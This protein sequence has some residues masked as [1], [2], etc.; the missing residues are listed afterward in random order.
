MTF[1]EIVAQVQSRLNLTSTE[2]TTRIGVTV[3]DRYKRITSAIG[4]NLSRRTTVQANVTI[5]VST[6]TFLLCEKIIN[7]VDRSA[8]PYRVLTECTV[9]QLRQEQPASNATARKYA[10]I[11][12]D[13]HAVTILL[14]CV[15]QTAFTLYADCYGRAST[16][17]GSQEPAFEEDFHDVLLHGAL[18]DEYR[19]MEKPA[20]A[21]ESEALYQERLSDLRMFRAKS[22]YLDV[23]QGGNTRRSLGVTGGS[24][25][26][27]S[28]T[29]GASSYTQTGLITFDR[30]SA[31]A[32]SRYP[33]AV[34]AGSEKVAN[35]DADKLDGLDSTAYSI[36]ASDQTI[37]G[38][39][40]FNRGAAAPFAVNA[41]SLK[42][43][44]LDADKLDGQDGAYY[45]ADWS[46]NPHA[47]GNFTATGGGTW[48]V[49]AADQA[50][51]RIRK[52]NKTLD[53]HIDLNSTTISGTVSALNIAIPFTSAVGSGCPCLVFDN[54][55]SV[56]SLAWA[57]VAAGGTTIIIKLASGANFAAAAN[58]TYVR[59]QMQIETT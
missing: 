37:T 1:A 42:V 41:A 25:G 31:S 50:S 19:K 23:M 8:T 32:G 2:S 13:A 35:L 3:N 4:I 40:T 6:L 55:T 18:A 20:Y 45:G 34:A 7:V 17:S 33:F 43:S 47:G 11:G 12:V 10:I 59:L 5:G 51:Y 24:G 30:T 44:N 22:S 29:N 53:V 39:K 49:D 58:T 54:S 28:S 38:L 21:R 15:P 9:E 46:T 57:Q 27:G 14:D 26:S 48:T 56:A 52:I 16:L 36:L